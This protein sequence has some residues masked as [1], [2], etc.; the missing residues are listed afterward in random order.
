MR[1]F[2]LFHRFFQLFFQ[3]LSSYIFSDNFPGRVKQKILW[4]GTDA[5][6]FSYGIV[7]EF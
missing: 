6:L 3:F 5:I 2:I 4:N 7:P 1:K